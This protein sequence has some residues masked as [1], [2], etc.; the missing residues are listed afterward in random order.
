M[1]SIQ[2][3]DIIVVIAARLWP[4]WVILALACFFGGW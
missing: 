2:W 4:L 1:G 3:I